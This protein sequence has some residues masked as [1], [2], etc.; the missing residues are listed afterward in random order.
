MKLPNVSPLQDCISSKI[1]YDKDTAKREVYLRAL[2][3]LFNAN[4]CTRSHL[5]SLCD[6]VMKYE[7]TTDP[8]AKPSN[9]GASSVPDLNPRGE[10]SKSIDLSDAAIEWPVDILKV[11]RL[12][13]SFGGT[14]VGNFG[15]IVTPLFSDFGLTQDFQLS[16]LSDDEELI[17]VDASVRLI[18]SCLCWPEGAT[19]TELADLVR[20]YHQCMLHAM[21]PDKASQPS[22]ESL[23]DPDKVIKKK[24]SHVCIA[25]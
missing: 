8:T 17:D 21:L 18:P 4:L 14:T 23:C 25:G 2:R 6:A 16:V 22:L 9:W 12:E 15:L 11:L 3:E 10:K 13:V 19:T 1:C 7:P 20:Q 5:G 24:T